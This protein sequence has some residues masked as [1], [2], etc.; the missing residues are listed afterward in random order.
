MEIVHAIDG[1]VSLTKTALMLRTDGSPCNMCGDVST[2]ATTFAANPTHMDTARR[3]SQRKTRE[4][5]LQ[6]KHNGEAYAKLEQMRLSKN[7]ARAT[8]A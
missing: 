4:Q 3:A 5:F 6:G 7:C 1:I 2:I 8:I